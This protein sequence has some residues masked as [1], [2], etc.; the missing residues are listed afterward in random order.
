MII[1]PKCNIF[2]YSAGAPLYH[3]KFLG[4]LSSAHQ[5]NYLV[6]FMVLATRK[7]TAT[8]KLL[9]TNHFS[10]ISAKQW[11]TAA[12]MLL[13]SC[14]GTFA[15]GFYKEYNALFNG[16]RAPE[17]ILSL[18]GG[19]YGL[20][21]DNA[22]DAP[23]AWLRTDASGNQ[24]AL[25]QSVPNLSST[26]CMVVTNDGDYLIVDSTFNAGNPAQ[27]LLKLEWFDFSHNS[28]SVKTYTIDPLRGYY[29]QGKVI[30]D[31]AGN[32]YV[33][34]LFS[35]ANNQYMLYTIQ[36][37]AVGN[38]L[39]QAPIS[40]TALD[41]FSDVDG[42]FLGKDGSLLVQY[43]SGFSGAQRYVARI[44]P[45]T[46]QEWQVQLPAVATGEKY[47]V[48]GT[49]NTLLF[50]SNTVSVMDAAQNIA[51][52]NGINTLLNE[53]GSII[54]N[55]FMPVNGGWVGIG[56][57]NFQYVLV[58]KIDNAGNLLWKRKMSF[59]NNFINNCTAGK[60]L[61][62]G[63]FLL[64]GNNLENPFLLKL[65]PDGTVF[66]HKITGTVVND[67]NSNCLADLGDTPMQSQLIGAQRQSDGLWLWATTD[68]NGNYEISDVDTGT[69]I[70]KAFPNSYQW[71]LCGTP[72][73]VTF[74]DPL[75]PGVA[76]ADFEMQN[77]YDCPFFWTTIATNRIQVCAQSIYALNY[78]NTGTQT[79]TDAYVEVTLPASFTVDSA[80][81]VYTTIAPNLLHF[82]VGDVAVNECGAIYVYATLDCDPELTGQTLCATAVGYPD[83]TC[84]PVPGVWSGASIEVVAHCD[85][86]S[87]RFDIKN[88][89]AGNMPA[90]QDYIIVEDHV[91]SLQ[92]QF[93]LASDASTSIALPKEGSTWRIKADQ[94][95][96]HPLG[97]EP[98]TV[99][100]EGCTTNGGSFTVGMVNMFSN[101]FGSTLASTDCHTVV[102]SY[103]PNEKQAF[104]IGADAAHLVEPNTS[105]DYQINFQNTGTA[106]AT[107][108][109]L[110]DSLSAWLNPATLRMGA[111]S[112]PYSWRLSG[113]GVLE[114][115]FDDINLP[116]SSSNEAASHG[117]VHFKIGQQKDNPLGTVV[118]NTAEI[119][120]DVN[121]AVVTNTVFHTIGKD[122]LEL[123]AVEEPN[124]TPIQVSVVPNP[125]S[126]SAVISFEKMDAGQQ[127]FLLFNS[128][129]QQVR[130]QEF[131]GQS[132]NFE[133]GILPSGAYFFSILDNT[134]GTTAH[135]K[136]VLK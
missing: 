75:T 74:T 126:E 8:M 34:G 110:R 121:P 101:N 84:I 15:Q 28:L 59:F 63:S 6:H 81:A 26:Q 18:A 32:F 136:L 65:N 78:C 35:N 114:I 98:A 55:F 85:P 22:G 52:T 40:N 128:A 53:S 69:Y 77:L 105:I 96:N 57:V 30:S 80:S 106:A 93:E 118:K 42:L 54:A 1:K 25:S 117:F 14:T 44:D 70:V 64:G 83:T 91:I 129:G 135:G 115:R 24:I 49:G 46:G 66:L 43:R 27:H 7:N 31:D 5:A 88:I 19:E 97:T 41:G 111:S 130:A 71:Q 94:E 76:I 90:P 72:D 39:W 17:R 48:D 58:Y 2:T 12:I 73:T 131:Y 37:D 133:R 79:A 104:P 120:F 112:H 10:S 33:A 107:T 132:L 36:F 116:D 68:V 61:P 9:S 11:L 51:W 99:A 3:Q 29:G 87:V 109:I 20:P 4:I 56:S 122:F 62:D 127:T 47:A 16:I 100:L 67:E 124:G 108:V 89:G 23:I 82:E 92:G 95:P 38:V 45:A 134:H 86:D 102:N 113:P 119:Y 21:I 13:L 103:D 125:M 123:V 50:K 60:E